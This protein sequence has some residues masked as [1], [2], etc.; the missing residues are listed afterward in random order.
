MYEALSKR[1]EEQWTPEERQVAEQAW[2]LWLTR[3]G[4]LLECLRA[5][6]GGGR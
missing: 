5:A 3:G 2:A 1:P 4:S 6:V